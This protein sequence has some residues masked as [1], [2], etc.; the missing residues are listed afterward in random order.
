MK[1]FQLRSLMFAMLAGLLL[2]SVHS[3]AQEG[4]PDGPP[5]GPPPEEMQQQETPNE[6]AS[7]ELKQLAKKLKLT[8][9]QKTSIR[10]I[11]V[12]RHERVAALFSNQS[13]SMDAKREQIGDILEYSD[14][15]I[16]K[17]LNDEQKVQFDKLQK[18]G[19]RDHGPPLE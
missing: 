9:D 8:E 18:D 4:P 1:K 6:A 5:P 13:S 15:S 16:R 7:H 19:R 14:N 3:Y 11:L 10:P 17:L 12:E 2:S